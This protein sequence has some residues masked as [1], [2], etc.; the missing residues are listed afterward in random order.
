LSGEPATES[1]VSAVL[2]G[3]EI[4]V[5][6]KSGRMSDLLVKDIDTVYLGLQSMVKREGIRIADRVVA[7]F[8][9]SLARERLQNRL[10]MTYIIT[11]FP[12]ETADEDAF[13]GKIFRQEAA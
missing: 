3:I 2:A 4:L 7:A 6:Q 13:L 11:G 10:R 5:R 8:E 1:Q 9:E 12:E